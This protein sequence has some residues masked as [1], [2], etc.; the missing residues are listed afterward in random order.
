MS[1]FKPQRNLREVVLCL[2]PLPPARCA[3]RAIRSNF[4][5]RF[6]CAGLFHAILN[7]LGD[8]AAFQ[9]SDGTQ[10]R[11]DQFAVRCAGINRF[12]ERNEG[13]IEGLEGFERTQEVRG[14]PGKAVEL[15]ADNSFEIPESA[16]GVGHEP[17]EFRAVFLGSAPSA[18]HVLMVFFD[19]PAAAPAHRPKWL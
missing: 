4:R 2:S 7:S 14:R 13:E 12:R 9:F 6:L 11:K 8:Q 16:L 3:R 17:V 10:D 15:P 18:I 19:G 5:P 1:K